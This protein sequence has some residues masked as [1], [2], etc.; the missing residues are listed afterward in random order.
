VTI[1]KK[2]KIGDGSK[3]VI[4]AKDGELISSEESSILQ[5]KMM[6]LL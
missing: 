6:V 3:T 2:S 1:H 4:K 5:L